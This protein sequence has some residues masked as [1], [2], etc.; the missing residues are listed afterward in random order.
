[1]TT[2]Y[3]TPKEAAAVLE[4]SPASVVRWVR[5]GLIP[6]MRI[7][8]RTIKIPRAAIEQIVNQNQEVN[9]K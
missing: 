8:H 2:K 9:T 7:G 5:E 6:A 4:V 3:L 1:M